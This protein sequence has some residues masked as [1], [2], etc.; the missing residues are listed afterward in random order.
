M[1]F[2]KIIIM[3]NERYRMQG[4]AVI[5]KQNTK[6]IPIRN[7]SGAIVSCKV[8]EKATVDFMGRYKQYPVAFEAKHNSADNMRFDRVEIHQQAYLDD[9]DHDGAIA[10]VAVNFNFDSAFIIPWRFY[11][12]AIETRQR[13]QKNITYRAMG[14]QWVITG[15]ASFRADELP[16]VW[17]VPIGGYGGFDYMATVK[18]VWGL[19]E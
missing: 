5:D 15:K 7:A 16:S 11:K 18:K 12:A 19:E 1:T 8:E 10:F 6:F 17:K 9:W 14:M 3:Q 2:E 4:D 13:Q